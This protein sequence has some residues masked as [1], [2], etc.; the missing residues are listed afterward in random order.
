MNESLGKLTLR[1]LLGVL[2]LL[3][4]I[5]KAK[6]GVSGIGGGVLAVHPEAGLRWLYAIDSE[7]SIWPIWP[8]APVLDSTGNVYFA[9]NANLRLHCIN[10]EGQARWGCKLNGYVSAGLALSADGALC[11]PCSDGYLYAYGD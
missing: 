9:D 3:H 1:L 4:G 7:S 8:S 11:V 6:N 2:M 10:S 5:A